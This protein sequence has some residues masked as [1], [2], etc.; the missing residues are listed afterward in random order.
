MDTTSFAVV[1]VTCRRTPLFSSGLRQLS[2][3]QNQFPESLLAMQHHPSP[4]LL[5]LMIA[6]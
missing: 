3:I 5:Y 2:I 1:P 6:A 4:V